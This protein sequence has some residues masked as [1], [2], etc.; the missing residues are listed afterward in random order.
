MFTIPLCFLLWCIH[1][2]SVNSFSN[3][4]N[5]LIV[6][7]KRLDF[8]I[9]AGDLWHVWVILPSVMKGNWTHFV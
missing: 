1:F 9:R 5:E 3:L 6:D 4:I 2:V 7:E 8:D